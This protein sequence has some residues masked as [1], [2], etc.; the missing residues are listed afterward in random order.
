MKVEKFNLMVVEGGKMPVKKTEGAACYDVYAREII[1]VSS[2][3]YK[4]KLGIKTE[5]P[6]TNYCELADRSGT[7]D[8]GWCIC[9]SLGF[10]DSDFRGEWQARFRPFQ[11]DNGIPHFPFKEGERVAQFIYKKKEDDEFSIVDKLTETDRGEGGHNST[12]RD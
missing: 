7:T 12:G 10:I 2:S 8:T 5:F 9:N 4:V 3:Y 1:R 11:S 6:I